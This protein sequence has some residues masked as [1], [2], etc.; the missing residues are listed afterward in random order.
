MKRKVSEGE[1]PSLNRNKEEIIKTKA[2]KGGACAATWYL[3]WMTS[4]VVKCQ[5]TP[6]GA[7][8]TRL[9]KTLNRE[10]FKERIQ[11]MEEGGLPISVGLRVNDPFYPGSCRYGDPKCIVEN[12]KD[13]GQMRNVYEI[14]CFNC[15]EAVIQEHGEQTSRLPGGQ[16]GP[17]YIWMTATSAHCR[18]VAH[19]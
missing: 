8:T 2:A 9:K 10:G 16:L 12:N 6:G 1:I 14:T 18:M 15:Q 13:C 19:L 7:L 11:V 17:N 3:R 4:K 5:S